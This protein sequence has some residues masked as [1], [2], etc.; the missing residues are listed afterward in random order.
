MLLDIK[1]TFRS[2]F[3]HGAPWEGAVP[4]RVFAGKS[5]DPETLIVLNA[6]FDGVCA[7]LGV[8]DKTPHSRENVARLVIKLA[9]GQHDP[10]L[11]RAAA[12]AILKARH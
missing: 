8:T 5:F 11:I 10:Q 3:G 7:D 6:A 2:Q 12:V 1:R 9:D 4:I